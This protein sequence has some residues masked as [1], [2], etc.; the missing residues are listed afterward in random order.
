MS[1]LTMEGYKI[2]HCRAVQC[3][4][5][6]ICRESD[7]YTDRSNGCN[8]Q[9]F[10]ISE[11]SKLKQSELTPVAGAVISDEGMTKIQK[12]TQLRQETGVGLIT[13]K[14]ALE[15][16]GWDLIGARSYIKYGW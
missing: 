7:W 10:I 1:G 5:E 12:I 6:T 13:A 16:S 4:F 11:A 2:Q 8:T 14:N 9:N 3:P 15:Y